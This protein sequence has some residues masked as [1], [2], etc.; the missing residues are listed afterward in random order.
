MFLQSYGFITYQA[1]VTFDVA[2]GTLSIPGLRD[3]AYI[4]INEVN[5]YTCIPSCDLKSYLVVT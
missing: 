4:S 2:G 5:L 3:R 1:N